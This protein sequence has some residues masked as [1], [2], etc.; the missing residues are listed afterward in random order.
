MSIADTL[1]PDVRARLEQ[2]GKEPILPSESEDSNLHESTET[3]KEVREDSSDNDVNSW[4]GRY[5][6]SEEERE[7]LRIVAD[8]GAF[9]AAKLIEL[10]EK[11]KAERAEREEER[12][13][14]AENAAELAELRAK[15]IKSQTYVSDED[16][17]ELRASLGDDVANQVIRTTNAAV[18][19]A[20]SNAAPVDF[21]RV[22]D[23][24]VAAR[25]G[26]IEKR[27]AVKTWM[28]EVSN[29]IPEI[30]GL[31]APNSD[32]VAWAGDRKDF[33]GAS[34]MDLILS[35]GEKH[36]VSKIPNIRTLLDEYFNQKNGEKTNVIANVRPVSGAIAPKQA[37]S[38]K[39]KMTAADVAEKSRIART[40]TKAE[41]LKFLS[42]FEE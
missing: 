1:P 23:E 13:I 33:S 37:G 35:A 38:G 7:R 30:Q 27:S 34:A 28:Q 24:K 3:V 18:A 40:G 31:L 8:N 36:D 2:V 20:L 32:F 41:L 6:K 17:D 25:F 9:A 22:V 26:D 11:H 42:K 12:R 15:S 4:R 10:S 19:K 5:A 29:T 16:A 14:A 39:R 21:D